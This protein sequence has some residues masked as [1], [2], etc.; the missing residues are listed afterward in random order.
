[1]SNDDFTKRPWEAPRPA[2]PPKPPFPPGNNGDTKPWPPHEKAYTAGAVAL[3]AG[4]FL[5]AITSRAYSLCQ[6][7][8]GQFAQAFSSQTASQC[9]TANGAH[10]LAVLLILAG[11]AGLVTGIVL[12]NKNEG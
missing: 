11:L 4:I 9:T 7:V 3:L 2:V 5:Y 12:A 10:L 8:P 1:M 6:S